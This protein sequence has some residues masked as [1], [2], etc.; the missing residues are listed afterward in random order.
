MGKADR[1]LEK[2]KSLP[3]EMRFSEIV[4]LLQSREWE[5]R[6]DSESHQVIRSPA[7]TPI[8]IAIENGRMIKRGYL[9][10][11]LAEIER[12]DEGL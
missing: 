6:K 3:P 7:G 9:R 11:I 4:T 2:L 10:R 8:T 12:Q 5:I 1:Y